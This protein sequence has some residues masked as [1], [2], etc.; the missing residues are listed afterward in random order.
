MATREET[1]IK[2][3][4]AFSDAAPNERFAIEL[5]AEGKTYEEVTNTMNAEFKTAYKMGSVREWFIADGRL[6]Q[7]YMEYN[8][9]LA[10]ESLKQARMKLK[11][12]SERAADTLL[13]LT[14]SKYD[15]GVRERA[16]GRI[17][18]KYIP[19]RQII[20]DTDSEE[21]IPESLGGQADKIVKGDDDGS[22]AG[23]DPGTGS[24]ADSEARPESS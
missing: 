11:R 18:N 7:A 2:K 22:A 3:L 4:P 12:A 24:T 23:D 13:E 15:A 14:S 16:A 19:D 8:D 20:F 9:M 21:S 6:N 5:R 17:L 1:N 10:A